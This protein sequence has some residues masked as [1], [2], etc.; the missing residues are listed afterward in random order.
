[1]KIGQWGEN[2]SVRAWQTILGTFYFWKK[3]KLKFCKT[4]K[5][6]KEKEHNY[7]F[8]SEIKFKIVYKRE[9]GGYAL[10]TGMTSI[11]QKVDELR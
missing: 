3:R 7:I 9:V 5:L 11:I 10:K 2:K 6:D 8:M 1:M 4:D